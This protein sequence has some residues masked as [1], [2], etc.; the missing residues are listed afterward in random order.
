MAESCNIYSSRS[1]WPVRELLDTPSYSLLMAI[2]PSNSFANEAA[3]L[4]NPVVYSLLVG[5]G[6]AYSFPVNKGGWYVT[7]NNLRLVA[8]LGPRSVWYLASRE[9]RNIHAV[10]PPVIVICHACWSTTYLLNNSHNLEQDWR[11]VYNVSSVWEE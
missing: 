11:V 4:P 8:V 7:S 1:R 2:F 5:L 6:T 10:K 9:L 3:S